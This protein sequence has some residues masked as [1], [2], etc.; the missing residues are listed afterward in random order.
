M[1]LLGQSGSPPEAIAADSQHVPAD[2]T[3]EPGRRASRSGLAA[4][5]GSGGGTL[6]SLATKQR[7]LV[8][9]RPPASRP[10]FASASPAPGAGLIGSLVQLEPCRRPSVLPVAVGGG[11]GKGRSAAAA[12]T[13]PAPLLL[14]LQDEMLGSVRDAAGGAWSVLVLDPTTTKVAAAGWAGALLRVWLA[15][16][17]AGGAAAVPHAQRCATRMPHAGAVQRGGRGRRHGLRRVA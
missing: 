17:S 14:W 9:R 16:A 2:P 15:A 3:R 5:A 4:M 11:S 10:R 6:L 1:Q 12:P 13:L 8:R 7:L